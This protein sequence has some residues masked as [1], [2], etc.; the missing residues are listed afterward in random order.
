MNPIE[1]E[2]IVLD[3][4]AY[5]MF[6]FGFRFLGTSV[7]TPACWSTFHN[8]TTAVTVHFEMGSLPWVELAELKLYDG[9]FVERNRSALELLVQERAPRQVLAA[10]RGSDEEIRRA[11]YEKGC[12]L[13]KYG[14]EIL[15]G[16]FRVF[17]R[18]KEL[19]AENL[20]RRN[21]EEG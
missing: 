14:A 2:T 7:H 10:G 12:Q 15:R 3:A 11:L 18:L 16:D 13:H 5:L 8:M 1:F 9:R 19:A 17:D 4:F 21:F 6:D 20:R